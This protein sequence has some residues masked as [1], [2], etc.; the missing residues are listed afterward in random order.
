[1]CVALALTFLSPASCLPLQG[2]GPTCAV[3][4]L[5]PTTGISSVIVRDVRP[6]MDWVML[7]WL[8]GG[9]TRTGLPSSARTRL[10]FSITRAARFCTGQRARQV[11]HAVVHAGTVRGSRQAARSRAG[12]AGTSA[13][14]AVPPG[15][16]AS[17]PTDTYLHVCHLLCRLPQLLVQ[18][19]HSGA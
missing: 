12:R 4:P 16:P 7:L 6:L 18:G 10:L 1:M 8:T 3:A 17:T 14:T 2:S 5:G 9:S 15:I 19:T 11:R 13:C